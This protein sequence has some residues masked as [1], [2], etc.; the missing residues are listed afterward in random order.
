MNADR[1]TGW[2]KEQMMILHVNI[3]GLLSG[4]TELTA[5]IRLIKIKPTLVCLNETF[6]DKSVQ[7]V[8]LE[9]YRVISRRDRD[10]GRKCG[11]VLLYALDAFADNVTELHKS[12]DSERLWAMVHSDIGPFLVGVWYRP[13]VQGEIATIRNLRSEW[14]DCSKDV[15][16]TVLLGDVNIHHRKWLRWSARNSAEGEELRSFCVENGFRQLVHGPTRGEYLLDLVMSDC[17]GVKCQVLPRIADHSAVFVQMNLP[18]PTSVAQRRW[19]WQYR[20]ANWDDLKQDLVGVDW[21]PLAPLDADAMAEAFTKQILAAAREHIPERLMAI[22]K[23]SHPWLNSR[24][25]EA[26]QAKHA[27]EGTSKAGAARDSCSFAIKEEYMKYVEREKDV[28]RNTAKS[29]KGWWSKTGRLLRQRAKESSIPA[30][31]N[32]AGEWV[33]DA[34]GKA[35]LFAASFSAK[36]KLPAAERNE[37]SRLDVVPWRPQGN[38]E[39][40]SDGVVEKT[41][42]KLVCDSATGPD[43]LPSKIL[44]E[45]AAA[46]VAPI[47]DLVNQILEE[48][49]WPQV[50]TQHWL[51]PLYKR[52]SVFQPS[53]YRGIHLTAQLGKVVERVLQTLFMPYVSTTVA[54]GPN[55][56]AY[57]KERGARDALAHLALVWLTALSKGRKVAVYCSDVSGAFDKVNADRLVAKLRARKFNPKIIRVIES[58]LRERR[59]YV[60]VGGE[61]SEEVILKN[62]VFQGTV[63]GPPL[64][65]MFYEDARRAIEECFFT[66]VVFADDLNGYREFPGETSNDTVLHSIDKCQQELHLWGKANNVEFDPSKESKHVLSFERPHNGRFKLLGIEFDGKLSMEDA[67]DELVVEAGWKLQM[68]IRSRRFYTDA[69]LVGLYKTHLLSF[70]EYRTAAI[71]HAR[72]AL[73]ERLDRVQ[74]KFLADLSI[75]DSTALLA[76][77]LAPLQTRRDIAMLGLIHR[78]TLGKGPKHF[79]EH[80]W[81]E[82]PGQLHDYRG[83]YTS[84][85]VSRSALGLAAIYNMLPDGIKTATSVPNFQKRLQAE[86]KMRAEAGIP[87]WHQTYSPRVALDNHP[88]R[89]DGIAALIWN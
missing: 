6:L 25:L 69:D 83:E 61:K 73:L 11:G 39:R 20:Q 81:L 82:R 65:N 22:K 63:L 33:L 46:L 30:L 79:K 21:I 27:A 75:D 1:K 45:C 8:A 44:K 77:N 58:W 57:S 10:D 87:D 55:Q 15:I 76:F 35:D 7:S 29:S 13:P 31:R 85:V 88:L 9:G 50:W 64:W 80:F 38:I 28:L 32:P 62:M 3:Q 34:K 86:L 78:T 59:G 49:R 71:Y 84:A 2:R 68:L 40:I 4:L 14:K 52:K 66:E 48:G 18:V 72:R 19:V 43:L 36:F 60:V 17:D 23:S 70:L 37:Y 54:F 74:T 67:I 47:R 24:I 51:V 56:F 5:R 26:V 41:L 16:G 12:H 53:N 42:L 89:L